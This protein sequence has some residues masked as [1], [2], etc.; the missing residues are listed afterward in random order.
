MALKYSQKLL[1]LVLICVVALLIGES[2]RCA[3]PKMKLS[4][5]VAKSLF[6]IL[7]GSEALHSSLYSK[8]DKKVQE[9]IMQLV[10]TLEITQ[11]LSVRSE[12]AETLVHLEKILTTTKN[13][14]RDVQ[15][16]SLN[17]KERR[18]NYLREFFQQ[19]I[20][21][22]RLY[23]VS[24][25][26]NVFFCPKDKEKGV[27]IQKSSKAQNPFDPDGSLKSCGVLMR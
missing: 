18:L 1:K 20:Q 27:W 11:A 10:K 9:T 8:D 2:G 13:R 22:T 4:Q 5:A 17:E 3:T 26:F 15:N 6:V 16:V 24:H 14:L 19:V 25:N 23:E 7:Q 12:N 21:I